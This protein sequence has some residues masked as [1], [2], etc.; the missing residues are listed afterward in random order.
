MRYFITSL[1]VARS[2]LNGTC[3]KKMFMRP[4]PIFL[5]T[6]EVDFQYKK[7][8]VIT[9]IKPE[10][11]PFDFRKSVYKFSGYKQITFFRQ[12]R[13]SILCATIFLSSLR[14]NLNRCRLNFE[15]PSSSSHFMNKKLFPVQTGSW[16][17]ATTFFI[18]HFHWTWQYAVQIL[19]IRQIV[20][21][22]WTKSCFPS[23]PEVDFLQRQFYKSLSLNL[24]ICRS[25]FEDLS[26]SYH[27]MSLFPTKLEVKF[28]QQQF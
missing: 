28:Q 19:K 12:N 24:T 6:P 1:V 20:L 13:K 27:D 21:I 11:M 3:L 26:I 5:V 22:L 25:N 23:K 2:I 18:N 8:Q 15:N 9:T 4:L 17:S 10:H 14:S 7:C 16:F